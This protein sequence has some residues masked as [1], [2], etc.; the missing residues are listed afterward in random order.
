MVNVDISPFATVIR[1][2]FRRHELIPTWHL[3]ERETGA[4][5]KVVVNHY[6]R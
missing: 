3:A 6:L 1:F 5:Q 2:A 4:E